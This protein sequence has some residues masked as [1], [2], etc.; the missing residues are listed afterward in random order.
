MLK[1]INIRNFRCLKNNV[2]VNFEIG[3][4]LVVGENDAGKTTLV[5]ALKVI[6]QGKKIEPADFSYGTNEIHFRIEFGEN[7]YVSKHNLDNGVVHSLFLQQL[8]HSSL[9]ILKTQIQSEFDETD[10]NT[11]KIKDLAKKLGVNFRTNTPFH[12]L[13]TNVITKI[14]VLLH[15]PNPAEF[16]TELPKINIYFLDGKHFEDVS[17]LINELYFK[18][19]KKIFGLRQLMK[20]TQ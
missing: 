6:F 8:S 19:K 20:L 17:M 16:E 4:T 15:G 13:V 18:E 1:K 7:V 10:Q 9:N 11:A 14:D 5:D 12:T 2:E 3:L